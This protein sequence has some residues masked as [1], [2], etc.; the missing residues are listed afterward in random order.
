MVLGSSPGENGLCSAETKHDRRMVRRPKL[1]VSVRRDYRNRGNKHENTVLC[2][3]PG[4]AVFCTLETNGG[5]R[6]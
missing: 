4:K 1:F 5:R 3:S 2:S 6:R